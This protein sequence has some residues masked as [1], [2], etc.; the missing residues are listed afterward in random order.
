MI[1]TREVELRANAPV[2]APARVPEPARP[3]PHEAPP[4]A[5]APLVTRRGLCF[6]LAIVAFYLLLALLDR[7]VFR[8]LFV[9]LEGIERL[10]EADWYRL[11]RVL[12]SL[13][14]WAAIAITLLAHDWGA[15]RRPP[16]LTVGS[17]PPAWRFGALSRGLMVFTAPVI[18]GLL[19][20]GA[21]RLVGRLR[22]IETDGY[23]VYLGTLDALLD[24]PN[25]MASSHVAV[26]FGGAM[27]AISLFPKAAWV[28]VP[29]ALGCAATRIV[30][31]AHFLTDVYVGAL[32]G[33]LSAYMVVSACHPAARWLGRAEPHARP[34][35]A[36]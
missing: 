27:V 17:P 6:T 21:K 1:V 36:P 18:A 5:P 25:G 30:S 20:E 7:P 33:C 10:E 8:S 23:Y 11:L 26:A 29:A 31:G 9:G 14:S 35:A 15:G 32:L 12:G 22:P 13:W 2:S 19:A 16:A 34:A 4:P 3:A 28:L 24:P